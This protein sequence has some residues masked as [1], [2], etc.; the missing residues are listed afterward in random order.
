MKWGFCFNPITCSL[1][2]RYLKDALSVDYG[3]REDNNLNRENS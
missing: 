1:N 3:A 2:I